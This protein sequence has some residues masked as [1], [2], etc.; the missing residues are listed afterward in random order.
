MANTYA[1]GKALFDLAKT[2]AQD[3]RAPAVVKCNLHI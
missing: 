2:E 1:E 3:L